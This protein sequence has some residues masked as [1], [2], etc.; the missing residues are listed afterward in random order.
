MT[1]AMPL[2]SII[3]ESPLV[4]RLPAITA[5]GRL[6][7][8]SPLACS[9]CVSSSEHKESSMASAKTEGAVPDFLRMDQAIGSDVANARKTGNWFGWPTKDLTPVTLAD[10]EGRTVRIRTPV[11]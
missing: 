4:Q 5:E 10:S 7:D 9:P 1:W 2:I 6:I 3:V 8:L 11:M